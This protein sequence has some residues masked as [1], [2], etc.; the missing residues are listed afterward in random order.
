MAIIL[1]ILQGITEWLPIS[2]SGHLAIIQHYFDE[3]PPIL[4]DII[5]HLGSL[6]VILYIM[7]QEIIELIGAIP[8]T[9]KNLR[10][11]VE[12]KNNE[13]IVMMIII[14]SVPTALLGLF[15]DGELINKFYDEMYL[16]GICLIFTGAIMW[17]CKNYNS[18]M[19]TNDFS[20]KNTFY[21]GLIQ[22]LS[23]LPGIS[24]SG[25]TIALSK[26][27]G[28][29]RMRAARFSFLLF[30]P[31]ILGATLLKLGEAERTLDEVGR[32]SLI[33]GFCFSIISS[34][35]SI[36]LLLSLIEKQ[37]FHYFSPYCFLVG[38]ILIFESLI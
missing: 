22:G 37:Q 15:F 2:S 3:E 13:R 9:F 7:R 12:L 35:L 10:D 14:A 5:L 23:I 4:Y 11:N 29:D 19:H 26:I 20:Y 6:V 21:V 30:I 17:S 25:T 36:K 24:R 27:L 28:L 38:F 33:L 34:F 32:S 8:T 31:A 1:G 18:S 16:V